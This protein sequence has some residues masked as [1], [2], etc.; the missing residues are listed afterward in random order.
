MQTFEHQTTV[1]RPW[2]PWASGLDRG[3]GSPVSDHSESSQRISSPETSHGKCTTAMRR[4]DREVS[5]LTN[6]WALRN[7][8][9]P[10]LNIRW[11]SW[12]GQFQCQLMKGII[13]I[14]ICTLCTN[15]WPCW[16]WKDPL[17][18]PR[19]PW[20]WREHPLPPLFHSRRQTLH[21]CA[22]NPLWWP[23]SQLLWLFL[24]ETDKHGWFVLPYVSMGVLVSIFC[25]Q[26]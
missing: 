16:Q 1:C 10:L 11:T 6:E 24:G 12:K 9:L 23:L 25:A 4:Q 15:N 13:R 2:I 22:C 20:S 5:E 3:L 18:S 17:S 26:V 21:R 14:C 19:L 7:S 8:L